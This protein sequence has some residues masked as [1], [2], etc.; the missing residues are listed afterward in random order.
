MRILIVWD[1]MGDY[2]RSRV[3]NYSNMFPDNQIITANL[4]TGSDIYKWSNKNNGFHYDLSPKRGDQ[5]D[6]IKRFK[7][8][9]TV[10]NENSIEKVVLSGYGKIEYVIFA[11]WL[12]LIGIDT[13]IFAES[14]YES[15][16]IK[17]Y[18]KKCYLHIFISGIFVS[19]ERARKF[20]TESLGFNEKLVH[21]GYSVVDNEHFAFERDINYVVKNV[22]QRPI[23]LCVAR[24]SAEKNLDFLIS[25]FLSSEMSD[26]WVLQLVGDGP[27]SD[28]LKTRYGEFGNIIFNGWE[29][30]ENLPDIYKKASCFVL[31]SEFEPWGLVVNEAMSCGL[32]IVIS[33]NCG[34]VEDLLKGNGFSFSSS[35]EN[36]LK[37]ILNRIATMAAVDLWKMGRRSRD[38]IGSY[39]TSNWSRT[40]NNMLQINS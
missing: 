20:Y 18:L 9:K 21:S 36:E 39:S 19:G 12:K 24:Y 31:A 8:F 15:S 26:N 23:M 4:G 37:L 30:Y 38:I 10:I 25:S 28:S 29:S 40:L 1:R 6:I 11:I 5:I 33:Q 13:Y 35:D 17:N 16:W 2:H 22:V 14:W 7:K 3:D 27:L 32:P 34:C